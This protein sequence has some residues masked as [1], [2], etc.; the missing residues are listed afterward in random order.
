MLLALV[1]FGINNQTPLHFYRLYYSF[2]CSTFGLLIA[3]YLNCSC[4]S[5]FYAFSTIFHKQNLHRRKTDLQV[6]DHARLRNIHKVH[7]QLVIIGS[8]RSN[9]NM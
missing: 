6:L 8:F 5:F 3:T 1:L 4:T 9:Y 2:Y 7:Q